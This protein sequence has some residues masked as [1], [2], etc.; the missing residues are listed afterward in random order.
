V[1]KCG[2]DLTGFLLVWCKG[3]VKEHGLNL[4]NLLMSVV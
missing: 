2:L 4:T 3:S 1:D